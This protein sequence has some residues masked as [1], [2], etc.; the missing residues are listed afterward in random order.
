M[1]IGKAYLESVIKRFNEY[2]SLG[3]K[4]FAQLSENDFF[5]QPNEASNS[6]AVI[7]QH[8]HGNMLSRWT[9][10]LTE[11][12]EKDWRQRDEEFEIQDLSREQL[13]QRWEEGWNLLFH[14][15]DS[16]T[17]EDLLKQITIRK[18][19]LIVVDAI[20]RQLAHYSSHVGQVVY[21]GKWIRGNQ[22]T[23]LSI[24]KKNPAQ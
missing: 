20:N 9:N 15:L 3:D 11:D 5:F 14:T 6:I 16:L 12:G 18:Q 22:W 21:L 23:S 13:I 1:D 19:P 24:P 17:N 7:I 4:T 8:M 2:K 10:F